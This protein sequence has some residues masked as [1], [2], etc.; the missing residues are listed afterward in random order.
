MAYNWNGREAKSGGQAFPGNTND[1]G[2]AAPGMSLRDYLAAQAMQGM[3]AS[4]PQLLNA[5]DLRVAARYVYE[6][7]D[8]MLEVRDE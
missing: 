8:A 6:V 1:G 3:L 5:K 2:R 4:H 7:A